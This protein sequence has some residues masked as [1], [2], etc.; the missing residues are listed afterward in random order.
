MRRRGEEREPGKANHH[1]AGAHVGNN[2]VEPT[3]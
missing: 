3:T 1:L 2:D